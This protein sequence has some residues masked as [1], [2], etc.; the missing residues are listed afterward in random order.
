MMEKK[1]YLQSTTKYIPNV[2]DENI[3]IKNVRSSVLWIILPVCVFFTT[4]KQ[5]TKYY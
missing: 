3:R 1:D 2:A 5:N 4:E